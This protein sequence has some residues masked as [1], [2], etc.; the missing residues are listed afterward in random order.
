MRNNK[1]HIL[2]KILACLGLSALLLTGF[3]TEVFSQETPDWLVTQKSAARPDNLPAV[4]DGVG[5]DEKLGATI[6]L[7]LV[8]QDE[9]G[10]D[11]TIGKYFGNGRP[12]VLNFAYHN[13]PMLCSVMLESFA[14]TLRDLELGLGDEFNVLTVSFSAVETADLAAR[15][16]EKYLKTVD[17]PGAEEG[18][19]F[20][21]G[22][23]ENISALAQATGFKF[24]W[25]ESTN[26]YA[27]PAA[28]IF[29]SDDG[30]IT[31]YLHGM[32]FPTVDV[33]RAIVEASRG[34]IGTAFDR[35]IMY[36]Y[37]YDVTA[38][39]YVIH[40]QNLMKI[41]GLL[42]LLVVGLVLA[43]FWRRERQRQVRNMTEKHVGATEFG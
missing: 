11:V 10:A 32:A 15:Q 3:T 14:K 37:R 33:R 28:L 41:A 16:K 26:E 30:V 6:P 5:I 43:V 19:H 18:W 40:A 29:L 12:V 25:V 20:L 13:C 34:E 4:F 7:S 27:H 42:T 23:E 36:C 24:K 38:N 2:N 17:R 31:R 21:T 35:I 9:S 22:S 8:F 39:S 1:I